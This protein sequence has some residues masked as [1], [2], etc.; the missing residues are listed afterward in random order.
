MEA[1]IV[2]VKGYLDKDIL[3]YHS[4]CFFIA[5]QFWKFTSQI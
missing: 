2:Q 5:A 1:Y 4:D 3:W